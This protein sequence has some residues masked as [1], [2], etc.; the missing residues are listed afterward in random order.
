MIVL[1]FVLIGMMFLLGGFGFYTVYGNEKSKEIIFDYYPSGGN[2]MY[3]L[4]CIVN[5]SIGSFIPFYI[6]ANMEVLENFDCIKNWLYYE[7]QTTNRW[8]LA[9][10][11]LGGTWIAA[12][13]SLVSDNVTIVTGFS[14]SVFMPLISFLLP[15]IA[16]NN[17]QRNDLNDKKNSNQEKMLSIAKNKNYIQREKKKSCRR[18]M[19]M[20][21]DFI[22]FLFGVALGVYG[23][24]NSIRDMTS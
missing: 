16:T 5:A 3:I 19:W 15:I 8:K 17:K 2:F 12:A 24:Y 21:H 4:V 23:I 1:T 18:V 10:L 7:D 14:G 6:I 22:L 11:R 9:V 13:C 20:F